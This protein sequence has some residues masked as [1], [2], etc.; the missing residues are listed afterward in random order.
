MVDNPTMRLFAVFAAFVTA[1][2]VCWLLLV[3]VM[4]VDPGG[5]A[6]VLPWL[7]GALAGWLVWQKPG[8]R[9]R[10]LAYRMLAG[11]SIGF[12][13]GFVAGFA[14]PLLWAPQA[15]QAPLLGL[16]ITGPAGAALGALGAWYWYR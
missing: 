10:S 15:N 7:M 16:F 13:A 2:V 8:D 6:F 14:G 11:A 12:C 5:P 9:P 3:A 1:Y 4:N